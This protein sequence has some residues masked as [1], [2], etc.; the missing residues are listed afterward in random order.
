MMEDTPLSLLLAFNVVITLTGALLGW[1]VKTLFQRIDKVE[2]SQHK[3]A[4][5]L[6]ELRVTLPTQYVSKS[7]FREMGDNIF[8]ALRRIEDRINKIQDAS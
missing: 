8:S 5:V 1:L 6:N 2:S 3:F 7:D 4:D